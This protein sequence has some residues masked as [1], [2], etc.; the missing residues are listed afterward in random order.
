MNNLIFS[1]YFRLEDDELDKEDY[2]KNV[3]SRDQQDYYQSHLMLNK[4]SYSKKNNCDFILFDDTDDLNNFSKQFDSDIPKYVKINFYKLHLLD[5]LAE[6]YNNIL[7]LDHDVYINKHENIFTSLDTNKIHI[8]YE[9]VKKEMLS[10]IHLYND[11]DLYSRSYV[12]KCLSSYLASYSFDWKI[13]YKKYN[14][15]IILSNSEQIKK[16][17]FQKYFKFLVDHYKMIYCNL[18]IPESLRKKFVLNNEALFA[19]IVA[20]EKINVEN[21]NGKWHTMLTGDKSK[22]TFDTGDSNFYHFINKEFKWILSDS[23]SQ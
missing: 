23:R 15:G 16:L 7:Y 21:L 18:D 4:I 3:F 14:T 11:R 13:D 5:K 9:N 19:N 8:W 20:E 17:K 6:E 1:M 2:N 12:S 10:Y 22:E